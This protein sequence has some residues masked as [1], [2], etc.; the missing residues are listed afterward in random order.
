MWGAD[1][2][3]HCHCYGD[4]NR[5]SSSYHRIVA[6]SKKSHHLNMCRNTGRPCELSIAVHTPHGIRHSVGS[7]SC[8]H[9]IWM[10]STSRATSTGNGEVRLANCQT[11]LFV[12]SCHGMLESCRIGGITCYRDINIFLPHNSNTFTHV[13]GTIASHLQSIRIRSIGYLSD[14]MKF[15]SIIVKLS[16]YISEAVNA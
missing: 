7:W 15:R 9:I 1:L 5:Y 6:H 12:R 2:F 16:L 11:L 8:S 13:I 4:S 3:I 14:D 10:Q